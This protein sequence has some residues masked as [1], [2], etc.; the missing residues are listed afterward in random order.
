MAGWLWTFL[1]TA[2]LRHGCG[3]WEHK[4]EA[5]FGARL[6]WETSLSGSPKCPMFSHTNTIR[7]TKTT[8]SLAEPWQEGWFLSCAAVDA[9]LPLHPG[10]PPSL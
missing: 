9:P 2:W 5:A 3:W 10:P 7:T 4:S 1:W 8:N 6:G